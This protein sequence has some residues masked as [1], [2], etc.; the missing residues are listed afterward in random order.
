MFHAR[1]NTTHME[2]LLID[3]FKGGPAVYKTEIVI[4]AAREA[5]A[6]RAGFHS[7]KEWINHRQ[8]ESTE[9]MEMFCRGEIK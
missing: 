7:V 4:H 8:R 9:W 3:R 1:P 2:N 5:Q 6:K